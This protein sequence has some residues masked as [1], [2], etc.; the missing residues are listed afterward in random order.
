MTELGAAQ[1]DTILVSP[2]VGG[3]GGLKRATRAIRRQYQILKGAGQR[4]F[5]RNKFYEID[6]HYCKSCDPNDDRDD[7]SRSPPRDRPY[8]GWR[9]FGVLWRTSPA[10]KQF[11]TRWR[12][13]G[14]RRLRKTFLHHQFLLCER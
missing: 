2:L 9:S 3:F 10:S 4:I 14:E 6:L 8:P 5:T 7:I 1:D 12:F 11:P 13:S